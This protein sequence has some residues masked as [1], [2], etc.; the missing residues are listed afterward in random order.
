MTVG[1]LGTPLPSD[2]VSARV[3][4]KTVAGNPYDMEN[5]EEQR[6]PVCDAFER[7]LLQLDID[8]NGHIPSQ[9]EVT[10]IGR[11]EGVTGRIHV[12]DGR[13]LRHRIRDLQAAARSEPIRL[14][15]HCAPLRCHADSLAV[16]C[17][18]CEGGP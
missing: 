14:D 7:L 16:L 15:C 9:A 11:D 4:R 18:P 13:G 1:R 6:D 2:V 5:D 12:W 3:D 17:E 8:V 10:R